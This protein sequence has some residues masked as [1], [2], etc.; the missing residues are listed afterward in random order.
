MVRQVSIPKYMKRKGFLIGL[1]ISILL[2]VP[3]AY[4]LTA[5]GLNALNPERPPSPGDPDFQPPN[6]RPLDLEVTQSGITARLVAGRF[7]PEETTLWLAIRHPTIREDISTISLFHLRPDVIRLSGFEQNQITGP[8]PIGRWFAKAGWEGYEI[9]LSPVMDPQQP[10]TVSIQELLVRNANPQELD[11]PDIQTPGMELVRGPWAFTFMPGAYTSVE[12]AWRSQVVDKVIENQGIQITVHSL[13]VRGNDLEVHYIFNY[14][15]AGAISAIGTPRL[16]INS[17]EYRGTFNGPAGNP[18]IPT[19]VVFKGISDTAGDMKLL[20]GPYLIGTRETHSITITLPV[21]RPIAGEVAIG[22]NVVVGGAEYTVR[23]IQL[24]S[25]SFRILIEAASDAAMTRPLAGTA[26]VVTAMDDKGNNYGY[27]DSFT[28]LVPSAGGFQFSAQA[29]G[30]D[31]PLDTSATG[32]QFT[33]VGGG[34][35]LYGPWEIQID[36][37]P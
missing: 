24:S 20:F 22:Q 6:S 3:L 18:G 10:V 32:L 28:K 14:Q 15:G 16:T 36:V 2:F 31:T 30:F 1:G 26:A 4:L 25:D 12:G 19:S 13:R 35:L 17:N 34:E 23:S 21:S 27:S 5:A 9:K 8:A 29:F 11:K 33:V 37:N 7:T